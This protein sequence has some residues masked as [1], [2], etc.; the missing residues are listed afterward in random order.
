[1]I[2]KVNIS[3]YTINTFL[4][5]GLG[6]DGTT[7]IISGT[8]ILPSA[9]TAYNVTGYNSAGAGNATVNITVIYPPVVATT[10]PNT[11]FASMG[12]ITP[13]P[14][15]VDNGL[16]VTDKSLATLASATV[17]I[18]GNFTGSQDVL[19][20]TNVP[21]SMGNISGNYNSTTGVLALTSS[22]ATATIA[23]WQ[24]ALGTVT[25]NNINNV[26][27]NVANRTIAFTASDG[28]FSTVAAAVKTVSL[29]YTPSHNDNLKNLTVSAG[30]LSPAFNAATTV[31]SF[32]VSNATSSLTVTAATISLNATISINGATAQLANSSA[33][34]P[35]MV[36]NNTIL[37]VVLAQDGVA[38]QTYTINITRAATQTITFAATN[39]VTYGVADFAPGATS[40]NTTIPITYISSNAAKMAT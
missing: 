27:P 25:Y 38:T 40:T 36:G 9:N 35:L 10:A 28:T 21:A 22:G 24:A 7:G 8:P 2:R 17:S 5:D 39:T 33:V 11:A 18:T 30:T 15:I 16:T 37:V 31:Y 20:F 23:Q 29:I 14:V 32:G 34:V 6:F 19:G 13:V 1:M 4:P 26:A 3:G 12:D